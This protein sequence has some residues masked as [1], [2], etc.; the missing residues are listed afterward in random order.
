MNYPVFVPYLLARACLSL[1]STMLSVAIGWHLYRITGDPFDLALVGLVQITPM[2]V[3]RAQAV[4]NRR[5]DV[6]MLCSTH[7]VQPLF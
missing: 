1:A 7:Q 4:E 3:Q 2:V 5:Q 6:V